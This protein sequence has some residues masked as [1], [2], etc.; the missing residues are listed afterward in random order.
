MNDSEDAMQAGTALAFDALYIRHS[1]C[2]RLQK[3]VCS[4]P[5][6][7]HSSSLKSVTVFAM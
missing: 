5:H 4:G 6:P 3:L 1:E 2:E 7:R